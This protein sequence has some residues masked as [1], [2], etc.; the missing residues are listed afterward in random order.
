[1][2]LCSVVLL[3]GAVVLGKRLQPRFGN[4]NATLLA[5]AAYTVVIGAVMA[6]LPQLGELSANVQQFG[7][8]ATETPLPLTDAKGT[9]VF[10]GFPADTLFSFRF[11]SVAAQLLLWA[12]IALVFGPLA[13]R[14]LSPR[15]QQAE[16]PAPIPAPVAPEPVAH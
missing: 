4:W 16:A 7:H 12:V 3:I 2:V 8:H 15:R 5:L 13:E 1:M 9:I 11:Y 14:L 10:P 6:L